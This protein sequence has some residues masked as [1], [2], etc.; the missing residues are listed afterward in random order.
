MRGSKFGEESV[1]RCNNSHRAQFLLGLLDVE[2]YKHG[3]LRIE[4]Q[5]LEE[6]WVDPAFCV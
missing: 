1:H 3:R 2:I 4:G 5:T 6:P